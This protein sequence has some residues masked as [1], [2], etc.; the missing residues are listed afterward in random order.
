MKTLNRHRAK[1]CETDHNIDREKAHRGLNLLKGK[2]DPVHIL[3]AR[4]NHLGDSSSHKS[5]RYRE[6]NVMLYLGK[7]PATTNWCKMDLSNLPL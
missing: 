6:G 3:F 2:V 1:Q 5:I 4:Y 7:L